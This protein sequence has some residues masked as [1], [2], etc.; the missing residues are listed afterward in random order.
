MKGHIDK[1]TKKLEFD[2]SN[3]PIGA[4]Q[5]DFICSIP[6]ATESLKKN[7]ED[8]PETFFIYLTGKCSNN[9]KNCKFMEKDNLPLDKIEQLFKE[10][11]N[12]RLSYIVLDGDPTLS[13]SIYEVLELIKKYELTYSINTFAKLDRDILEYVKDS[14][15]KIQFRISDN[16]T[17]EE[18]TRLVET[19][20]LCNEY[21][22][23][24]A[25][26]FSISKENFNKIG[27]MISFCKKYNVKQFS[28]SRLNFCPANGKKYAFINK[29]EYYIL[30]KKLLKYREDEDR[31]IH[32]TSNDAIWKG[33]GACCVS[34][35]IYPNG[36]ILPCA[37]IDKE[38]GNINNTEF[39][40]VWNNELFRNIRESNLEGKC[41]NCL[42]KF[43][44]KGCRA[45][46]YL[47]DGNYQEED[48][49]CW[50]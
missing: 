15:A 38:T 6:E 46:P 43:L 10:Q 9:C 50:I 41:G 36:E 24:T 1:L 18:I 44:C 11:K 22:I 19:L 17:Q 7:Y 28:F 5:W 40:K 23:Y 31:K 39:D 2:I 33:C 49:G 42:Y 16:P 37:F 4:T 14:I 25:I 48:K 30:S 26:I 21:N 13:N 47:E 8:G 32:I 20:K 3:K 34:C 29:E 45:I 12:K 27:E 35:A